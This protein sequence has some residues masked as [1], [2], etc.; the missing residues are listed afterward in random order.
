M[1]SGHTHGGQVKVPGLGRIALGP[2]GAFAA[3]CTASTRAGSYV[4]TDRRGLPVAHNV[5][6]ECGLHLIADKP[7]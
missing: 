2:A 1:L 5:R 4:N 3:G 7:A 6:P